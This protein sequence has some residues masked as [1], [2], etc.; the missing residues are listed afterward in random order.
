MELECFYVVQS[1]QFFLQIKSL[2]L[3][4]F[5]V[6]L[7]I[8]LRSFKGVSN[9]QQEIERFKSRK[10]KSEKKLQDFG[11]KLDN[12]KDVKIKIGIWLHHC[13]TATLGHMQPIISS[14]AATSHLCTAIFHSYL[15]AS[16]EIS[17][18]AVFSSLVASISHSLWKAKSFFNYHLYFQSSIDI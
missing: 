8:K 5:V 7:V 17:S 15:L 2:V 14:I 3:A 18:F 4:A 12:V 10:R 13:W 11:S 9:V 1:R 16:L 6:L